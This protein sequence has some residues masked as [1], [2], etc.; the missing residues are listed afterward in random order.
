MYW[1]MLVHKKPLN[2]PPKGPLSQGG[3]ELNDY[4][5]I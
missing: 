2:E 5:S 1:G 3:M 4:S